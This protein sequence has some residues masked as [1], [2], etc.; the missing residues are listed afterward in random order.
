MDMRGIS[1]NVLKLLTQIF[2][3]YCVRY[4]ISFP[5]Y[6]KS[7]LYLNQV[8]LRQKYYTAQ[9][10]PNKDSNSWHPDH[11]STWQIDR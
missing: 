4:A 10:W 7:L 8:R 5:S 3:T 2:V 6:A 1:E 11:D 9:A